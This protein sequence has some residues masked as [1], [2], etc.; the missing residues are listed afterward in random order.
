MLWLCLLVGMAGG[1]EGRTDRHHHRHST[2]ES[3]PVKAD[4]DMH[5]VPSIRQNSVSIVRVTHDMTSQ[6]LSRTNMAQ[7]IQSSRKQICSVV[8]RWPTPLSEFLRSC[9]KLF[10][11]R[12][13]LLNLLY[14]P[15]LLL[16]YNYSFFYLTQSTL[17][18]AF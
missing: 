2:Y 13:A 7:M 17:T 3:H 9:Q 1:R 5:Y 12:A 14:R 11:R 18:Y 16:K 8:T 4:E 10:F 15:Y 6:I